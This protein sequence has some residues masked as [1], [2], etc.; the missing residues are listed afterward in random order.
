[1]SSMIARGSPYRSLSAIARTLPSTKGGK[2]VHPLT[3]TRWI[4]KGVQAADGRM[5][6]LKGRRFPGGWMVS[7]EALEEFLDELTRLAL[8]KPEESGSDEAPATVPISKRRQRQLDEADRQMVAAGFREAEPATAPPR[9]RGRRRK[10][11]K[12]V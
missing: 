7:D 3:V 10:S 8:T 11:G 4:K 5:I 2:P 1:M 12:E 9:R 6:K